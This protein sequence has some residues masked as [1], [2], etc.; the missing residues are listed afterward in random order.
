MSRVLLVSHC[1]SQ[2]M[3]SCW[4]VMSLLEP[5]DEQLMAGDLILW[6]ADEQLL[7]YDVIFIAR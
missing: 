1:I 7:V 4:L 6:P 3:S 5:A 2:V